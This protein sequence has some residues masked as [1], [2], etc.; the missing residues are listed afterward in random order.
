MAAKSILTGFATF[1]PEPGWELAYRYRKGPGPLWIFLNGLGDD[2]SSWDGLL[3]NLKDPH[4]LQVDLRGQGKSLA[5]AHLREPSRYLRF[6]FQT[7]ADDLARLFDFLK[8]ETPVRFVGYS[9]GGGVAIDFASRYPQ[10]VE[11]VG[12]IAP[13]VLRLDR[14][15]PA[16]RFMSLQ[17]QLTK[18]FGMIPR[19]ITDQIERTYENF[20]NHYLNHRFEKRMNDPRLRSVA[21]ELTHEIMKFDS[22]PILNQ[23]PEK[24]IFLLTSEFDT[25]TPHSLY[26]EFW[27]K[28]P[29]SKRGEWVALTEGEHL[30]LEE[31]PDLVLSWFRELNA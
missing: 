29:R 1:E 30:L 28:V 17:W 9:Y 8:V 10:R 6:P 25:L 12:L 31:V 22:F 4:T 14:A 5:E 24:S 21:I 26:R 16:Q 11:R 19:S 13:F 27:Q 15:F 23:L 3:G 20:L 2:F 18:T 7:H